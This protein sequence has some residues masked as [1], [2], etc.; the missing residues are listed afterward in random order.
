MVRV[1]LD[2]NVLPCEEL[3]RLATSLG[4][5]L[6]VT[7][8]TLRELE[9]TSFESELPDNPPVL[10]TAVYGESRWGRAVWG[11]RLTPLDKILAVLANGG[12]PAVRSSLSK[13]QRRQLRDAM[14]LEA[15]ARE[16]RDVFVTRDLKAFI[17][18]GKREALRQ[19]LGV[20]ILLPEEYV[21]R[22]AS[23]GV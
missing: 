8:V 11:T 14:A 4:H 18:H 1:T 7:T 22:Y 10:E 21:A 13:G 2:T 9:G 16:G 3:V 12:F 19:L 23:E 6:R 20:Q 15:H 5:D 17:S